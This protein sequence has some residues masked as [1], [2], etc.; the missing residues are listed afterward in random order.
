MIFQ[1]L[2]QVLTWAVLASVCLVVGRVVGKKLFGVKKDLSILKRSAQTLAIQ[3]RDMG[4]KRLPA[5]L[6][7]FVITDVDALL[8]SIKELAAVVKG[9]NE[10]IVK[11]LDGTFERMLDTKLRSPEGRALLKSK[12]NAIE[13]AAGEMV[14]AATPMIAAA[15]VEAA[16]VAAVT[17]AKAAMAV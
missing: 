13:T 7:E 2:M 4:L 9:G 6:E 3:L 16:K 12:L 17:A 1:G 15:A 14:I 8:Q 10:A 11:E 5:I